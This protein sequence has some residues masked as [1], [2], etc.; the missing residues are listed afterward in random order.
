MDAG[1]HRGAS[2][3]SCV[4]STPLGRV[5]CQLIRHCAHEWLGTLLSVK[6]TCLELLLFLVLECFVISAQELRLCIGLRRFLLVAD[7][8]VERQLAVH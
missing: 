6:Q 3:L 7:A 5:R 2:I 8:A 4:T 1:F